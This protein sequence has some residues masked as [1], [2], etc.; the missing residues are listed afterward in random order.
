MAQI[1][2]CSRRTS[3]AFAEVGIR[4]QSRATGLACLGASL[5]IATC[6]T[7]LTGFMARRGACGTRDAQQISTGSV[8][9][10]RNCR[11]TAAAASC[12]GHRCC[13][14][15]PQGFWCGTGTAGEG[16]AR[17]FQEGQA[18]SCVRVLRFSWHLGC[19]LQKALSR[20]P[21]QEGGAFFGR[22]T[23]F[24][25]V[26]ETCSCCKG[27]VQNPIVSSK[28]Y[29]AGIDWRTS[30][31]DA[32][33]VWVTARA[34]GTEFNVKSKALK[35]EITPSQSLGGSTLDTVRDPRTVKRV[36]R[37]LNR[38]EVPG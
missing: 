23:C 31:V 20:I 26:A 8:T 35:G 5:G 21:Q 37:V 11:G 7:R 28:V 34:A 15:R 17:W 6:R 12:F 9:R 36:C 29:E 16:L 4:H 13:V 10:L 24:G 22:L 27:S 19:S 32:C 38:R 1:R 30:V 18:L 25:A 33:Q 14:L 3:L 2:I